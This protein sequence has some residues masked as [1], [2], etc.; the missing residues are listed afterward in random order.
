MP[1]MT[2]TRDFCTAAALACVVM[3]LAACGEVPVA[4]I[5]KPAPEIG[6]VDLD[7]KAV[8]IAD[9]RGHVA[10]LNFWQGGCAPCLTEMPVIQEFYEAHRDD[11]VRVLS[12]N[13]GGGPAVV[14]DTIEDV[15][16]TYDFAYDEVFVA[17]TRYKVVFFPTTFVVDK[18]GILREKII[19][20][21]KKGTLEKVVL[22]LL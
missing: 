19:G 21:V 15:G 16:V 5:G 18:D 20:E 3:S 22:P 14:R 17:S 6:A 9:F 13:I 4:E 8:R 11:G 7:G 12:V 10:I 1:Q 2:R